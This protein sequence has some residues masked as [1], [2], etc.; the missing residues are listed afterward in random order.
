MKATEQQLAVNFC[1]LT[2]S[3]Q[4]NEKLHMDFQS[5]YHRLHEINWPH[6]IFTIFFFSFL[7]FLLLLFILC[8][9]R[10]LSHFLDSYSIDFCIYK[11]ILCK[12][13]SEPAR[14]RLRCDEQFCCITQLPK[15]LTLENPNLIVDFSHFLLYSIK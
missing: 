5:D 1:D 6:Y 4:F 8:T 14:I 7:F 12:S 2:N 3:L 13:L 10:I 15:A 9:L 11:Y